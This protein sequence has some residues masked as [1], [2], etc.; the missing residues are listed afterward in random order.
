MVTVKNMGKA[1]K[2]ISSDV[3][4][5]SVNQTEGLVIVEFYSENC[6][7]CSLMRLELEELAKEYE[8]AIALI[9]VNV[10]ENSDIA[11][12]H[13]VVSTP[14]IIMFAGGKPVTRILGYITRHD[15]KEKI[16]EQLKLI[17]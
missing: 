17:A 11:I 7:F 14:T 13:S 9:R 5:C 2:P 16:D 6:R 8:G 12:S 10:T 4:E 1:A 3:F 15:L